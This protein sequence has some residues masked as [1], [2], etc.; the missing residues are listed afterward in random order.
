M[1]DEEK[2]K[3]ILAAVEWEAAR[4]ACRVPLKTVTPE[5]IDRL[6]AAEVRLAQLA[7]AVEV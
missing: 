7:A 2:W 4:A 5:E 1:T 3:V 6:F